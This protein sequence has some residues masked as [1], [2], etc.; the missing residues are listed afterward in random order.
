MAGARGGEI[1]IGQMTSIDVIASALGD[2]QPDF[3]A[4]SSP[5]GA[6]TLMLCDLE[7]A[8][9][10]RAALGPERSDGLLR[11]HRLIVERIAAH[12]SGQIVKAHDDGFMIAFHSAHAAVRCAVELQRS[13][14]GRTTGSAPNLPLLIRIGLHTGFV[15]TSGTDFYG[16]N[17]VLAARVAGRAKGGEIIASSALK[18]YTETDPTIHFEPRGEHHFKG[19]IGE[20]E[21]FAVQ[22]SSG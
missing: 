16:R 7:D 15:I 6:L 20:H 11:D 21:L 4:M 17:V 10:I 19:V 5:D 12:H 22:W 3:G 8:A 18:E 14:D 9:S 13:L 2:E 1:P